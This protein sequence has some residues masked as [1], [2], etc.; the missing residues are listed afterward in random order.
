MLRMRAPVVKPAGAMRLVELGLDA[1][2]WRIGLAVENEAAASAA[3]AALDALAGAVS[4][5]ETAPGGAWLV[6]AWVET[7]PDAAT[8]A[9][10]EAFGDAEIERVE[11]R[12]WLA[13]NQASFPP[14]RIGRF[15]VYGSH[16][17]RRPPAGT[18]PILV[19]A[20]TAF[21]TGEHQ[22]TRG[23][24]LALQR[25]AGR[26][27]LRRVLD[28]G[29]GTGILA[30]GAARLG[31]RRVL[32]PDI[33]PGSVAVACINVRRNGV[34][35]R[36]TPFVSDGYRARR[37]AAAGPFDLIISNILARPLAR[38]APHLARALAP[39]GHAVLSGLL[40]RQEATVLAAHRA[41][42]LGLA[43]RIRIDGWTT[44][45]LRKGG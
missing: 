43:A 8:R 36:V 3:A 35:G 29:T 21:G 37:I 28:M 24:L 10:L 11:P 27:R 38:M 7:L 15:F 42:R 12:D 31:A 17:K 34:V 41:Q 14:L 20:T 4:A 1:M 9:V 40:M 16:V 19:D 25:L 39:R 6:E 44:L 13:E 32:A 23:C 2:T 26:R 5:F 33:D 45:V 18:L 22:T 30:V